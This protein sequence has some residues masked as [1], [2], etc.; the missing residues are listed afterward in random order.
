M[1]RFDH[2]LTNVYNF[3]IK[4]WSSIRYYRDVVLPKLLEEK[5]IRISPFANR[6]SFDAPPAV[7]RLRCLANYEALRFSS[8]ILSLGETLVARMKERSANS[9]GKYLSVHLRFEE[10]SIIL[11]ENVL[12]RKV[13]TIFF[14][15]RI[16]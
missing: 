9:G 13:Y 7:Q 14:L 10:V 4:A 2:N 6:L 16:W 8:P 3:R 12:R 15:C 5:V 1:E 11:I